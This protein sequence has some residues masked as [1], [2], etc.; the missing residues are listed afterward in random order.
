VFTE[1]I[2]G[3]LAIVIPELPA[4]LTDAVSAVGS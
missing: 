4:L 2:A 3:L 1:E